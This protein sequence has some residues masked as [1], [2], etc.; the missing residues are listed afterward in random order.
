[1]NIK[2]KDKVYASILKIVHDNGPTLLGRD[3]LQYIKLDCKNIF[4]IETYSR[5]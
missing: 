1:M 3:W 5:Y 2:Y 4:H